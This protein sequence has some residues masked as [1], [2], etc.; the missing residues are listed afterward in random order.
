MPWD[1]RTTGEYFDRLDGTLMPNAGFLVG[2]SAIRRVVMKEHAT[3]R[4][5]TPDELEQMKVSAAR[6]SRRRRHGILVDVVDQ[7]HNDHTG[8]PVPSRH[9]R[10]DEVLALCAVVKE[11]PGHDPRVH[12]RR[13]GRS[14]DETFDL[15][16]AM[17]VAANRPLNWNLLQVHA[18]NWEM[19]QHQLTGGDIAAA[20]GGR[21]LALTLPDTFRL[22]LNLRSGFVLDI[23]PGWDKLMALPPDEKLA[24]LRDPEGRAE[25]D[26]L[27][28]STRRRPPRHRQLGQLHAARNVQRAVEAVRGAAHR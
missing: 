25:M 7:S 11:F 23:L 16:A 2:H 19:V 21:V 27:A 3:E 10:R 22:R 12:P 14:R 28:Q 24:M 20:E 9:A 6:R 18:Q 8:T 5:A 4:E 1:W 17:S 15:M 13:S 26:R